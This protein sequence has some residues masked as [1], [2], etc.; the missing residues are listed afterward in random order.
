MRAGRRDR[1]H[2]ASNPRAPVGSA[3]QCPEG[4]GWGAG[5]WAAEGRASQIWGLGFVRASSCQR[6]L[7]PAGLV[8]G[9]S[10]WRSGGPRASCGL[11][12]A[13]RL[14]ESLFSEVC[15]RP[16]PELPAHPLIFK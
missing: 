15:S 4:L 5:A 13:P 8:A 12:G 14:G 2:P 9:M 10:P 7:G 16:R 1:G 3:G 6:L 11:P